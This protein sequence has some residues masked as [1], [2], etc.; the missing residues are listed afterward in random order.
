MKHH[1]HNTTCETGET[2][3]RYRD[4]A[5]KQEQR[6]LL[7]F[8]DNPRKGF[9]PSQV[10]QLVMPECPPTSPRRAMSNLTRDNELVK[11]DEKR[12][13][14]H[15]RPEHVWVLAPPGSAPA[16]VK[17]PRRSRAPSK[18]SAPPPG[19]DSRQLGL[20]S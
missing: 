16:P 14:P 5:L 4:Q 1:H 6:V 12:Q 15:G 13:G 8:Q 20:F 11:L 3:A 17:R 9:T 2:L 10:H 18:P 7:L 19:D